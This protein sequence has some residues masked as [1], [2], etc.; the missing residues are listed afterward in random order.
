MHHRLCVAGWQSSMGNVV[1]CYIVGPWLGVAFWLSATCWLCLV[2]G[3]AG[4]ITG[5]MSLWFSTWCR[6]CWFVIGGAT[7]NAGFTCCTWFCSGFTC[8]I[9]ACASYNTVVKICGWLALVVWRYIGCVIM[10]TCTG[11]LA[12]IVTAMQALCIATVVGIVAKSVAN[13]AGSILNTSATVRNV[14]GGMGSYALMPVVAHTNAVVPISIPVRASYMAP[15]G[16]TITR[17]SKATVKA[18]VTGTIAT[19]TVYTAGTCGSAAGT[20]YAVGS[21]VNSVN[22]TLTISIAL[23]GFWHVAGTAGYGNHTCNQAGY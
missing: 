19:G 22:Y 21:A 8:Y 13:P 7:S 12:H 16:T 1:H 20:T 23:V 6:C 15:G 3:V 5:G 10:H 4:C 9:A 11:A 17:S 18:S 2:S 14:A